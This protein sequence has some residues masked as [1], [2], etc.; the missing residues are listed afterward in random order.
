M[1]TRRELLGAAAAAV[2]T[3]FASAEHT[4]QQLDYGA[5]RLDP[6]PL[7]AQCEQTHALL[8]SLEE[9]SLLRPMRVREGLPA[10]GRDLGG[11][12]DTYAFAP[13]CTFGQ[14]VSALARYYAATGDAPTRDKVNRLVRAYAATIEP[15]GKFYID[16]RFPA[17]FY[18][19]MVCGLMDA[20]QFVRD[21]I[22]LATLQRA[23]DAVSNHL[24]PKAMPHRDTPVLH[25]EDF[26]EH[27]WDES[28]TM[29]ENLFIAWQRTGDARYRDLAQRF[30]FDEY[31]DPLARGENVLPGR[32]A[33]SH[34][35][36]LS[37]AAK[38]YLVIG[39]EK[40]LK[41]A[42]NGLRMVEEQS[43]A[44]GGW[45]PDEHFVPPGS[46]KLGE[47]LKSTHASFETP[48]GSYAHFKIT[49][50]LLRITRDARYGDSMERV[51][52]N[53]VLGAKPIQPDGR[54]FYYSDYTFQGHKFYH[55]DKWP[56]CSGTLPQVAADYR[57]ST[58]FRD[59]DH[60]Y[61]NLYV[62]SAAQWNGRSLRQL[63][64]YPYSND[65]RLDFSAPSPATFSIF[66]RIPE[67]TR[68]PRVA[69]SGIRDSRQ[70]TPGTFAEIRREW[71]QGDRIELELPRPKRLQAVDAQHPDTVAVMQGPLVLM[72][73]GNL[74]SR[75]ERADL[76]RDHPESLRLKPFMDI[77]DEPYT[78][79]LRIAT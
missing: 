11:W 5:V 66:L 17:Y 45:G 64:E 36:A 15:E 73:T 8:M 25:H 69:V 74:P 56:C 65:V 48:C 60:L 59:G 23:T 79:Y 62:P 51:M 27:C 57:I 49:R 53:T 54:S 13:A 55:P 71:K 31:F 63:T 33:Y 14:W 44:T 26:T 10:P 68:A 67:W 70:L 21:P 12:Y 28:Y 72:A 37:S 35:N 6:G 19:K 1:I 16:N 32:H 38:A 41:A 43:Y 3:S 42:Q 30:L 20:H 24:P 29:P 2:C 22:A 50:Y 34:V 47:S 78:T 75:I 58:Y 7:A 52:Y 46:G 4:L 61:V 76:L 40:Y 9:D 39:D 77:Q 18:D